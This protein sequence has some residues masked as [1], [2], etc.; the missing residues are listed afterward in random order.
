[1][2][3]ERTPYKRITKVEDPSDMDRM[4][5]ALMVYKNWIQTDGIEIAKLRT[6][7]KHL[8]DDMAELKGFLNRLLAKS[9]N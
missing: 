2:S 7:M 4:K 1:M 9:D 5:R 8:E 3:E 6:R